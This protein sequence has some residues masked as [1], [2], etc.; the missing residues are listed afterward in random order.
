MSDAVQ[1]IRSFLLQ[2]GAGEDV[3]DDEELLGTGLLDS[4]GV[5]GLVT[6]L[7][8]SFNLQIDMEHLTEDNF[9]S[10]RAIAELVHRLTTRREG[11]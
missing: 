6:Q 4:V 3:D 5:L 8:E 1:M 9:R 2:D 7:E 11:T 10:I